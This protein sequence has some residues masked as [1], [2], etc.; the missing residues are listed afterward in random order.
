MVKA[1]SAYTTGDLPAGVEV[2]EG[3]GTTAL[4]QD[5]KGGAK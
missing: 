4:V 1:W 3:E 2:S 5:K